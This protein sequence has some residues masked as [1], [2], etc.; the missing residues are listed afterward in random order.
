MVC[1]T[2]SAQEDWMSDPNLLRAVKKNLQ[3]P[4]WHLLLWCA[5]EYVS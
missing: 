2:A 3:I 1:G 4:S 5:S